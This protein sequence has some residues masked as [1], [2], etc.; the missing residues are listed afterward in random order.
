VGSESAGSVWGFEVVEREAKLKIE[1]VIKRD[2]DVIRVSVAAPFR[3]C[4]SWRIPVS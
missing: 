4:T 1:P 2:D 3:H